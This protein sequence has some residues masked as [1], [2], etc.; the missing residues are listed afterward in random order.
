MIINILNKLY[1]L[2][3]FIR[4]LY[5]ILIDCF[6]IFIAVTLAL[7]TTNQFNINFFNW[8][9]LVNILISIP[10]YF[11]SGIYYN[12]TRYIGSYT[13]YNLTK[14]NIVNVLFT[15]LFGLIFNLEGPKIIVYIE[16]IILQTLLIISSRTI[17]K[18]IVL[19]LKKN[20]S[21]K[22]AIYG[23][24]EAGSQLLASLRL[25]GNLNTVVFFDD[26]PNLWGKK[27]NQVPIYPPSI[28]EEI[29]KSFKKI[30]LAIPSLNSKRRREIINFL[31]DLEIPTLDIPSIDDITSGKSKINALRPIPID[32]LLGRDAIEA[33]NELLEKAIISKN[34]CITGAGGSIGSELC[35]QALKFKPNKIILMEISELNLYKINEELNEINDSNIK[36]YPILG[37]CCDSVLISDLIQKHNINIIFHAAA[38]KHVPLVEINPIKGLKNNIFSTLTICK[39][40]VKNNIEKVILISTDKS[41]R[42]TNIMGASKRVAEL[43]MQAYANEEDLKFKTETNYN[44]T[45]F[46]IVRFGNV[47]GSSG[48]VVPKFEQ[49]IKLGGPITITHPEII[50]YFMTIKEAA[51]LVIQSSVLS[52]GGDIFLL[53]MGK[54]IKIIDL[55]KQMIRLSGLTIKNSVN[56]NGD[57]EIIF[58]GLRRGEKLYE[59]LLINAKSVP[60]ENPRIYKAFEDSI[61][62]S[63]L[64]FKISKMKQALNVLDEEES[65]QILSELVPEWKRAKSDKKF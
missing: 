54:Q 7:K 30:L 65:L 12:I 50:R 62:L 41:V 8:I 27:I 64:E 3:R 52:V 21:N 34:I 29:K 14:L 58:T 61:V 2:P 20:K 59:E 33:Q 53:D 22:V 63:E 16:I 57:I 24:G 56:N 51:Q 35:K 36:I 5:L 26:N 43:I 48:S 25:S 49:Q 42:P 32:D 38:Y 19:K 13:Y 18:D 4:I 11:Y 15:F 6:S 60:T 55:A 40:S 9:I 23:A 39:A 45:L 28:I 44:K 37:S 10:I 47:L 46:S 1:N 17:I 31:Q